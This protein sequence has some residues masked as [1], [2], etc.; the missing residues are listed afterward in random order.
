MAPI[1][2]ELIFRFLMMKPFK[3]KKLAL[4]I[5]SL[6][7]GIMH[8]NVVQSTYAIILGLVL[9]Y[10]YIKSDNILLPIILHMTINTSSVFALYLDFNQV[11]II[12]LICVI[13]SIILT[14]YHYLEYKKK[15]SQ[16]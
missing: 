8:L 5:T 4:I 10:F 12:S 3:N 1:L 11:I 6:A 15:G 13:F 2:E 14:I 16:N 9:G 7:F